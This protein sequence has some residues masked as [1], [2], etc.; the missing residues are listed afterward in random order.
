MN[1]VDGEMIYITMN[2]KRLD[3]KHVND[4]QKAINSSVVHRISALNP[5]ISNRS[6]YFHL[7]R[8]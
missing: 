3:I 7:Y 5:L 8:I 4:M 2:L 6:K 1:V